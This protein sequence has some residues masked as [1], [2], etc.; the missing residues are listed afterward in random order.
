MKSSH[1]L[2]VSSLE[3][4][5]NP[6]GNNWPQHEHD[7]NRCRQVSDTVMCLCRPTPGSLGHCKVHYLKGKAGTTTTE[8]TIVGW[9]GEGGGR[10]YSGYSTVKQYLNFAGP[11]VN[12][13]HV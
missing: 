11:R 10:V 3:Q 5:I 8:I 13:R 6:K 1:L 4:L 7:N 9:L 12:E 2:H